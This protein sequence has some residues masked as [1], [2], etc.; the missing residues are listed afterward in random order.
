MSF[1]VINGTEVLLAPPDGWV[2]NFTHPYRNEATK[3][4]VH[5]AFGLEFPIATLFLIQRLYTSYFVLHK[6]QIEDCRCKAYC[7]AWKSN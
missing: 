7:H 6:L 1:P 5:L 3:S 4:H 2:V